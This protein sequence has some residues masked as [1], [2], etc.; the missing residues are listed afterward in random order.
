MTADKARENR[1]RRKAERLGVR[2][3]KSRRRDPDALTYGRY[4]VMRGN[5]ILG[6]YDD[7]RE[8]SATLDDVERT[9]KGIA[10]GKF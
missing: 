2:L 5:N 1:L 4:F 6:F 8:C 3:E 9:L 7:R 10:A